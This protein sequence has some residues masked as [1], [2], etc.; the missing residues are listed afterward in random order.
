[1]KKDKNNAL[2]AV[3]K[4]G[5][6]LLVL[7]HSSST[8]G[9]VEGVDQ[10]G[11]LKDSSFKEV[12]SDKRIHLV[13]QDDSFAEIFSEFYHQLRDPS[14]FSFF[15]VTEY[16]ARQTAVDLQ[17]YVD[18]ASEEDKELLREYEV[19]IDT[20]EANRDLMPG[21]EVTVYRVEDRY[22]YNPEQVDWTMMEKVG[23]SRDKL[24]EMGALETMLKGYKTPMLLPI[25]FKTGSVVTKMEARLSLRVNNAGNL[26]VRFF[27]V[28]KDPDFT[29]TF[30]G[31]QFTG[32]DQ[33][34]LMESGNMGRVVDLVY[35]ITGEKIPSLISRDRL[36]NDLIAVR[37]GEMRIPLVIKGVT[38]NE[39][40]TKVLREGRALFIENMLS[41]RG[42]LFNA[43]V[44]YNADKQYV[45]F[46]FKKNIK[47]LN[48]VELKNGIKAEVPG[49]FR[50]KKLKVWQVEKLKTGESAYI[51]GLVDKNGKK[52]QGYVRFDKAI[53]K[54][55][56]S[57][58]NVW[59][60]EEDLKKA[61]G[62]LKGRK[63]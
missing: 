60:K 61:S 40:Q 55:E 63:L 32:E 52:Y 49:T 19:S 26:E 46:L 16:E 24:L 22:L 4:V 18:Q 38:L 53:G 31:H 50:G 6:T 42:T 20:V 37:T 25:E 33:K 62:K 17:H 27:P 1:M 12:G 30:L 51:D 36:T 15:K 7:H 35:P 29:E 43:S 48:M 11:E 8:I 10:N 58:R 54:F 34:N 13:A 41:S 3:E 2:N 44:Q 45:E 56:F 59:K 47:S 9:M 28:R 21:N 14:D 5:N 57:F 39:A 23:L